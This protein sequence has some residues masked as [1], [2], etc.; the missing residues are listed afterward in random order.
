MYGPKQLRSIL[1]SML[2]ISLIQKGSDDEAPVV[3]A[4]SISGQRREAAA[5]PNLPRQRRPNRETRRT[6]SSP[7]LGGRGETDGSNRADR[8]MEALVEEDDND[9]WLLHLLQD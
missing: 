4:S 9:A 3:R 5:S 6:R 7:N 2:I 8:K 1:L